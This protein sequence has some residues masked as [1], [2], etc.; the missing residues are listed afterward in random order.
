MPL[1][2]TSSAFDPGAP[3]PLD[4]PLPDLAKPSKQ[5]LEHASKG[6]TREKA[7]LFGTRHRS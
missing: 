6:H 2:L 5:H 3:I 1:T 4:L 7:E